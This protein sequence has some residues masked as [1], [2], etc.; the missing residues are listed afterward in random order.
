MAKGERVIRALWGVISALYVVCA[1]CACPQLRE[2]LLRAAE[3]QAAKGNLLGWLILDTCAAHA[4]PEPLDFGN[5]PPP[6][7]K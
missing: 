4:G 1:T 3:Q 7:G 6:S 2:A 5:N